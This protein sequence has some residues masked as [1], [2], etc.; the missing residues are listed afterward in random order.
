MSS[1]GRSAGAAAL[2][3]PGKRERAE[4]GIPVVPVVDGVRWLAVVSVLLAHVWFYAGDFRAFRGTPLHPLLSAAV[5]ALDL[6]FIVS[7]F[8][9]FL[10][11]AARAGEFG[12]KSAYAVRRAAR[13]FP[14]YWVC[15]GLLLLFFPLLA[16]GH[17]PAF[18]NFGGAAVL[19]HLTGVQTYFQMSPSLGPRVPL[20]FGVDG[21]LW[22][23]S[24]EVLFYALLPFIA[25]SFYRR[26]VAFLALAL[27]GS[28]LFRLEA[29]HLAA[30][31]LALL[32]YPVTHSGTQAIAYSFTLQLPARA[33]DFA[34]GMF[35]AYAMVRLQRR[36]LGSAQPIAAFIGA[37]AALAAAIAFSALFV[38]S[39]GGGTAGGESFY[40]SALMETV[41]P[42]MLGTVLLG[43]TLS[44]PRITAPLA[45][46]KIV[47]LAEMSYGTYLYHL[48]LI[49]FGI[50]TLGLPDDPSAG[51]FLLVFAFTLSAACVMGWLSYVLIEV[52]ARERGRRLSR[53]LG[54]RLTAS[55]GTAQ[56]ARSSPPAGRN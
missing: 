12:S 5:G 27:A 3:D 46:R 22:T 24:V 41:V 10:P 33:G 39:H 2:R 29:A 18:Y 45:T 4:M 37:I 49:T 43:I 7:G 14:A 40:R 47:S 34:I 42:L 6:F 21:A 48:P 16:A 25:R 38:A 26:P 35:G 31:W 11:A 54:S 36:P 51:S 28:A 1:G 8:V 19:A 30:G 50:Y 52:P 55:T 56:V 23:L 15:L 20:G 44:P 9:M 32:G 17:P 53:S 13:I